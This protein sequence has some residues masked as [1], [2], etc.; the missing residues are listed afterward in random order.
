MNPKWSP[1]V[2]GFV[3]WLS[4]CGGCAALQPAS[5]RDVVVL[6]SVVLSGSD[7]GSH[8]LSTFVEKS[9]LTVFVFYSEH[10]PTMRAHESRLISWAHDYRDQQVQFVLVNSE[11]GGS[12]RR[13]AEVIRERAYPFLILHDSSAYLAKTW[14]VEFAT[15]TIII[16]RQGTVQYS[17]GLDSDAS[18]L[19]EDAQLY[20]PAALDELLAHGPVQTRP[21]DPLGCVLRLH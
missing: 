17:G 20:L 15:H 11:L 18:R 9:K 7:G 5:S 16:D 19:R 21:G 10:C 4:L 3:C 1:K 8:R 12:V 2:L 6:D 14:G 13:D